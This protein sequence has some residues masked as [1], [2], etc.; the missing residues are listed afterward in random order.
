MPKIDVPAP[1][2]GV[3]DQ[4][5]FARQPEFATDP[6]AMLNMIPEEIASGRGRMATRPGLVSEFS[7]AAGSGEVGGIGVIAAASGISGVNIGTA[8]EDTN[9]ANRTVGSWR[10]QFVVLAPIANGYSVDALYSDLRGDGQGVTPPPTAAFGL[11]GFGAAFD[12]SNDDIG[13]TAILALDTPNTTQSVLVTL[14]ARVDLSNPGSFTHTGGCYDC[15]PLASFPLPSSG[16]DHLVINHMV[17]NAPYVF[18]AARNYI[19]VHTSSAVVYLQR[20]AVAFAIEAQALDVF[21][22]KSAE[23]V[24]CAMTGSNAVSG[25]VV[26]DPG[27]APLEAFGEFARSGLVLYRVNYADAALKTPVAVNGT[28]LTQIAMPQGTQVGD[29]GYEAHATFRLSEYTG[30][31]PRGR[32]VY[33][34]KVEVTKDSNGDDDEVFA[35]VTTTNQ[36]FGYDGTQANQK[37][38]GQGEYLTVARINLTR[39]FD[40]VPPTYIAPDTATGYGVNISDGGWEGGPQG[41]RRPF[42]WHTSSFSNDIPAIVSGQRD[43]NGMSGLPSLFA[44]AHSPQAGMVLAGGIRPSPAGTDPNVYG[45]R[46]EDGLRLFENYLGGAIF[47]NCAACDPT[48][49]NF[50]VGGLRANGDGGGLAEVWELNAESGQVVRRFDLTDAIDINGFLTGLGVGCYAIDVNRRGQVLVALAPYRYDI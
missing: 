2:R 14:L 12:R 39:A 44:V 50:V 40:A 31:R 38:D 9:G 19:Y 24:L 35:Y 32:L 18:T 45:M 25:P 22:Y 46:A 27:P 28:P 20:L 42:A 11:G 16:Q 36:G 15:A 43:P 1:T 6:D 10:G 30:P 37:P 48:S 33:S 8:T 34:L 3:T 47:Q 21:T 17:A 13:F 29:P 49:G 4:A 23:Y 7:G 41:F 26:A 5:T